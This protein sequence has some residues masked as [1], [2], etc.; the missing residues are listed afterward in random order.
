MKVKTK[1]ELKDLDEELNL[2][3]ETDWNF[4]EVSGN[5]N[6][7]Y[8]NDIR[9]SDFR[10]RT[11]EDILK[12]VIVTLLSCLVLVI[13][14]VWLYDVTIGRYSRTSGDGSV[15]DIVTGL[16]RVDDATNVSN[17]DYGKI[18][19]VISSYFN[20]LKSGSSYDVLN[21]FCM[22]SSTFC[23]TEELFRDKMEY[24]YDKNDCYS[25]VLKCF[26]GY[27]SVSRINEILY[28][29]D[30]YY[31]YVSL[32]FPDND[33]LTEYFYIYAND[34]TKYFTSNDITEQNIVKY[35]V[36]LADTYGIPTSSVEVCVEMCK[37]GNGEFVF[38]DDSF[39][40]NR[41]TSSYNYAISQVTRILGASKANTQYE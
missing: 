34:M 13:S 26:G 38:M 29:D 17:E 39:V 4:L 15:P 32:N 18:S 2:F 16:K 1:Q 21:N 22:T 30:I 7:E 31:A 20:I 5:D 33:T 40:T 27:F 36:K 6:L 14:G 24:A 10:K 9:D 8:F 35:I 12:Y 28:K 19:S 3:D 41:C 37:D 23:S 25:R 11:K